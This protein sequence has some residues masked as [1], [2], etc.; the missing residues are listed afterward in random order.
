[1]NSIFSAVV[2]NLSIKGHNMFERSDAA[3]S[4]Y[5]TSNCYLL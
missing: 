2:S 4:L 3:E 5:C 1:M